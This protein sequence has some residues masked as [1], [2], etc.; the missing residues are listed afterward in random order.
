MKLMK[1]PFRRN[2]RATARLALAGVLLLSLILLPVSAQAGLNAAGKDPLWGASLKDV[3]GW[4]V[5]AN[6]PSKIYSEYDLAELASRL[7][8]YRQVD[9]SGCPSGGLKK[10]GSANTCGMQR[11]Q[12]AVF[13]WQNRFNAGIIET[14][15]QT[16]IPPILLKNIFAW[17]SQ[18][19]PQTIYVNTFEYGLGHITEMG[20]DSALRWNA[21]FYDQ[22]CAA[23]LSRV[24]CKKAY[25]DQP[26][27]IRANLRGVVLQQVRADCSGC[28]FGLDMPMAGRSIPVFAQTLL[29]NATFVKGYISGLTG[30]PAAQ[31]VGYEDLW[32]FT[33]TSYNAGPGCFMTAFS[34]TLGSGLTLTWNNLSAQLDPGCAGSRTYVEF[35]SQKNHYNPAHDPG[36]LVPTP[37]TAAPTA[38][39]TALPPS[40]ETP[41]PTATLSSTADVSATVEST[42]DL[43]STATST[44]LDGTATLPGVPTDLSTPLASATPSDPGTE[45]AT[46]TATP[47]LSGSE[48]PTQTVTATETATATA[49]ETNTATA[50]PTATPESLANQLQQPHVTNEVVLKINSNNRQAAL[51]TLNNLGISLSQDS[52]TIESLDTLIIQVE[53]AQLEGVLAALQAS[54]GVEFAEPN[55]LAALASTPNDPEYPRQGN[56]ES[57]QVPQTWDALPSMQ[58]VLVAVIDTGVD[59]KH[60]DLANSMWQNAGEIGLDIN[61]NDKK[62]NGI[63]DDNNGYI[64]DWQGWNFVD[65]NNNPADDQA[66]GT[67]LTGI[68]AA[69][70]NNGFGIAGIAPNARILPVKVLDKTGYGSYDQVAEGIVYATDMGARVINLGFGGTGS[71][72]LLQNAVD[73]ALAHN[74]LV[75]ASAG[76]DGKATTYYPGGYPGVLA[77]SA[78]DNNGYWANFSS[79]GDHISLAAPGLG[80]YSTT[81]GGFYRSMS[82]TSMAAAQVSGVAALLASQP[83]FA[84]ANTL[85]SALIGGALDRGN[86]G[87]D[88]FF[89]YGVVQAFGALGYAGPVQPTATPWIV[90]TSTPGGTAGVNA[91]DIVNLWGRTQTSS[92]ALIDPGNIDPGINSIDSAFN[93]LLTSSTG[94]WGSSTRAWTF[95]SFDHTTFTSV[96]TVNIDLRYYATGWVNDTYYVQVYEPTSTD[97][98]C[99]TNLGWCTRYT[100]K[101]AVT[102]ANES[103]PAATLSTITFDVSN[104]LDTPAKINNAQVRIVGASLTYGSTDNVTFYIDEVQMRVLDVLPPTATPTSTPVFIPTSTLPP[105]RA[106]TATPQSGEPHNHFSL[107]NTDQCAVCHRGHSAK[108]MQMRVKTG[109]EQVCFN[110]HTSGGTGTNVQPAFTLLSNSLTRFFSHPISNTVNIHNIDENGGGS[111][112]G[113]NRHVECEDCHQPHSSSRTI[114]GGSN[115]APMIQQEMAGSTGVEP[116]W[117]VAGPA[118]SFTWLQKADK[119]FQLCFKCHSAFAVSLP[120]YVPDGYGWDVTT[121]TY[122]YISNGL[123]K[124]GNSSGNQVAD[125]RDL[126]KEFN[127]FQ[128]SFHPVAALGRNRQIPDG[129]FV[130]GW[131]MDSIISCGD[132]HTN[133]AP[134]LGANG[135]HGSALVHIL[136]GSSN[137]ITTTD[138]GS[139]DPIHNTGEL[140]FKCHQYNTYAADVNP[141]TTTRFKNGATNLHAFHNFAACYTCHDTHGSE[142]DRLINFDTSEV[143][144]L[145][146]SQNAWQFD[147]TINTG[148]CAIACHGADHGQ[149]FQYHP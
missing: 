11:A 48:T 36:L 74:V 131:S 133:N 61:G 84:D 127:S 64:D 80:I 59:S 132:C 116:N 117:T 134:S 146:N 65:G 53:P 111:F 51:D 4:L 120:T 92:F 46:A 55:Y 130:S 147:P 25:V 72:E 95:T 73:Y 119:E 39:A 112:G 62:S 67:H 96:A 68:I 60:P 137:Y 149:S 30:H 121:S 28:Q 98:A 104:L 17:E 82:G 13:E 38:S 69:G 44:S 109:E 58:E 148:T 138:P 102:L 140:C 32:K 3:P 83:Q 81:P 1:P 90:P 22:I 43:T 5:M 12:S 77:V 52:S 21:P 85:R 107:A 125:S 45:T 71:S 113:G 110:C 15:N 6:N 35:I 26:D 10:N 93:D 88:A 76:N 54:G 40:S 142:Q 123:P 16:G 141:A 23:S 143:G 9:A 136:D 56:L 42:Q 114:S 70:V 100:L 41:S 18:F 99:T 135:P 86:P 33:L 49:T 27:S 78:V 31:S 8:I 24:T 63:D 101:F 20:A 7:I 97:T 106:I 79:S 128:V 129:S 126:A 94:G 115:P 2:F 19:W 29:A 139:Q 103:R 50:Q 34:R 14:S 91:M 122:G 66:H 89:G 87:K 145:G 144:V 118:S 47:T 75:V 57:I 124:L 105:A 37:T 108:S